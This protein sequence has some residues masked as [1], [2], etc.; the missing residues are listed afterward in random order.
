MVSL[1]TAKP[2]KLSGANATVYKAKCDGETFAIKVFSRSHPDIYAR[3][4]YLESIGRSQTRFTDAWFHPTGLRDE[5]NVPSYP[6]LVMP[7]VEGVELG[8]FI[9]KAVRSPSAHAIIDAVA[10]DFSRTMRDIHGGDVYH[11]DLHPK[12]I[13]VTPK[14]SIVLVDYDAIYHQE[15]DQLRCEEIGLPGFYHPDRVAE[16]YGEQIDDFAA[17]LIAICL[18]ALKDNPSL[19]NLFGPSDSEQNRLLF[20]RVDSSVKTPAQ[21]REF[22]LESRHNRAVLEVMEEM[23]LGHFADTYR[24]SVESPFESAPE[25]RFK[26]GPTPSKRPTNRVRS[27]PDLTATVSHALPPKVPTPSDPRVTVPAKPPPL[28]AKAKASDVSATISAPAHTAPSVSHP[29]YDLRQ[30]TQPAR[31]PTLANWSPP[32]TPGVV[33][34]PGPQTSPSGTAV[35]AP[36]RTGSRIAKRIAIAISIPLMAG[37]V[38][39]ALL[40]IMVDAYLAR[41]Y[42]LCVENNVMK[43]PAHH[44]GDAGSRLI[45]LSEEANGQLAV[46][47]PFHALRFLDWPLYTYRGNVHVSSPSSQNLS[48]YALVAAGSE[49]WFDDSKTSLRLQDGVGFVLQYTDGEFLCGPTR[50]GAFIRARE[51]DVRIVDETG[52]VPQDGHGRC[53]PPPAPEPPPPAPPKPP[54]LK[55]A[56]TCETWDADTHEV[57]GSVTKLLQSLGPVGRKCLGFFRQYGDVGKN[58]AGGFVIEYSR[59]DSSNALVWKY[60][61]CRRLC[62]MYVGCFKLLGRSAWSHKRWSLPLGQRPSCEELGL[63]AP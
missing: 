30:V 54:D 33:G 9:D 53:T 12:N 41:D 28:P 21:L 39:F 23:N 47:S 2:F 40:Q 4:K 34:V 56:P 57:T 5:N 51:K 7:W 62:P 58:G 29:A 52:L 24:E 43:C 1:T 15:L 20:A 22:M 50:S 55:G 17:N 59:D 25:F 19:W 38:L 26:N 48:S 42:A 36:G 13:L 6:I 44:D 16:H 35:I 14:N 3:Y 8:A 49:A 10:Y 61:K 45:V 60:Q 27:Y 18:Y 11:G 31:R 46:V 63:G 32:A 37:G